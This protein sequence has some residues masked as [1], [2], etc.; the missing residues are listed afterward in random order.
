MIRDKLTPWR[1]AMARRAFVTWATLP[2][3]WS[4]AFWRTWHEVYRQPE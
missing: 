4:E 1:I 3:I 2:M